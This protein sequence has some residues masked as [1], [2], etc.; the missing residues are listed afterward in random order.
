MKNIERFTEDVIA[1]LLYK[2][3]KLDKETCNNS[4]L[5]VNGLC[6]GNPEPSEEDCIKC[7]KNWLNEDTKCS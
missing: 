1:N 4:E 7:I 3:G 5:R 2:T 6:P